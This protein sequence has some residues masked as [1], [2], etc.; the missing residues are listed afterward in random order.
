MHIENKLMLKNIGLTFQKYRKARGYSRMYVADKLGVS[1]R[2]LAAYERGEREIATNLT[3]K[4]AELYGTTF[5][6]LTGYK[7]YMEDIQ[8]E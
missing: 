6:N 7:D 3:I 2:T 5:A 1:E 4:L 8:D